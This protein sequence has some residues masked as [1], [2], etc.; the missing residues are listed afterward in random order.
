MFR[1]I[2]AAIVVLATL[3]ACIV[4]PRGWGGHHRHGGYDNGHGGHHD[5]HHGGHR[6]RRG[7][8]YRR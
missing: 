6:G 2:I 8:D 1:N 7:G 5:G 3:S 4:V